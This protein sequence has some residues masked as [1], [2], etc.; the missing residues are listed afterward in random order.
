MVIVMNLDEQA[1]GGDC[2]TDRGIPT[3]AE[4][5][6]LPAAQSQER[7]AFLLDISAK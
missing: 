1:H 5:A 6:C 4:V 7:L 3:E 2:V